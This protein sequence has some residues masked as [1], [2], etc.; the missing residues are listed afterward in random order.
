MLPKEELELPFG[1]IPTLRRRHLR[2]LVGS[3]YSS[4]S[5]INDAGE[6]AGASNTSKAILPFIWTPTGESA[7]G[8]AS[9]W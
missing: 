9:A 8:A 6:V 5:A 3:D 7:T 4:A 1:S 2:A